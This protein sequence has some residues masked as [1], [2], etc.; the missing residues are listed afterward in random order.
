MPT[1]VR[2]A[3]VIPFHRNDAFVRLQETLHQWIEMIPCTSAD[4]ANKLYLFFNYAGDLDLD[5]DVDLHLALVWNN[6]PQEIRKCFHPLRTWSCKL[7]EAENIY[8]IGPCLQFHETFHRLRSMGFDHWLLYEPDVVPIRPGWGTRLLELARQNQD[9]RNWWQLGSTAMHPNKVDQLEVEGSKGIDLHLNGNAVYCVK[10][11]DFDEYR[12]LVSKTYPARGC[13]V[14]NID[15]E[16]AGYDHA[17]YRFRMRV[18]NRAY[19]QEKLWK[20]KDD[21]FIRNFGDTHFDALKMRA[22]SS[23]T[24][25]VH[26]KY[27][28]AGKETQAFLDQ[29]YL[30]HDLRPDIKRI[31]ILALGRVPS[32]SEMDFFS[33]VLQPFYD[34]TEV[35]SCLFDKTISLCKTRPGDI[36]DKMT[37]SCKGR[38][39]LSDMFSSL[40][41]ATLTGLYITT[42]AGVPGPEASELLCKSENSEYGQDKM[43]SLCGKNAYVGARPKR[44]NILF[45]VQRTVQPCTISGSSS[46]SF[47]RVLVG[48]YRL[49]CDFVEYNDISDLLS[50]QVGESSSALNHPYRCAADISVNPEK[51]LAC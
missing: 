20:F 46:Q 43:E 42:L 49:A 38:G 22:L 19:M 15:D 33:R 26:S 18:E 10:S 31:Y 24:M 23:Q 9:C 3:V 34:D 35:M 47:N 7:S 36:R 25:L 1:A 14:T 11:S 4:T 6:L 39:T 45:P 40:V 37:E 44:H 13:Y 8:P 51:K 30:P 48:S 12:N 16:L 21:P 5:T 27:F 32:A 28:F 17:L 29:K 41:E 50:C 2:V